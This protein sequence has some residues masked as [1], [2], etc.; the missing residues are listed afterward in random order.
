MHIL[1]SPN[2]FKNSLDADAVAAAIEKGL[3]QSNL[4]CTTQCFP[5]GD[6][7]DGTGKLI[8]KACSGIFINETV[9]DPLGREIQVSYGIIDNGATAVI[10]MATAS[11]L[12]LIKDAERDPLRSS[13]FGT[14]ELIKKALDR[15][16]TKIILCVGGSA[17]IDGGTGILASLGIRFL[18]E[19]RELLN[20]IPLT[21]GNMAFIDVS[22]LDK[23]VNNCEIIIICDVSNKLLGKKGAA[24][25][26]GPQKGANEKQV[27][28]LELFLKQF[29]QVSLQTTGIDMTEIV[30]GGAA[31]GVAAGLYTFLNAR[32]E[33]GIDYFL[34]ITRFDN[35]LE[36]A[37]LVITGEGAID[38]Q[39]LDGKAPFGVAKKSQKRKIP[40][41]ALA[42]SIP[43]QKN[44]QLAECFPVL[45]SINPEPLELAVAIA[46]TEK[47]LIKT[48]EF[49]GN[50]LQTSS[51][52]VIVNQ[53][54]EKGLRV[55]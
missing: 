26:F 47:N 11:G 38:L 2:A 14:G 45:L 10:E 1:I 28:Q 42:G 44:K 20:Y 33:N 18:D 34:Q 48:G 49:L 6:G 17:T 8:T 15:K 16:V 4:N 53:S 3:Q 52:E 31:G 46:S 41:F 19:N 23:R 39:T 21:L 51:V 25:I 37:N 13:S 12:H 35:A 40:V 22:G 54:I 7:G 32:L 29:S 9:H 30:H 27:N 43:L 36:K 5:I 24:K 50:L 55:K